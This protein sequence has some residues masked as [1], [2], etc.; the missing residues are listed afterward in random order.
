MSIEDVPA[1]EAM[2]LS[3]FVPL[4]APGA[5]IGSGSDA[6][7]VILHSAHLAGAWITSGSQEAIVAADTVSHTPS[8]AS[9]RWLVVTKDD[10]YLK[11][12]TLNVTSRDDELYVYAV[13]GKHLY[14]P[15]NSGRNFD[16][17]TE[18]NLVLNSMCESLVATSSSDLGYGVQFLTYSYDDDATSVPERMPDDCRPMIGQGCPCGEEQHPAANEQHTTRDEVADPKDIHLADATNG[19]ASDARM[20]NSEQ[21][22]KPNAE[23]GTPGE[24]IKP[25][26]AVQEASPDCPVLAMVPSEK[27]TPPLE[28]S[29][30]SPS[31]NLSKN[32]SE[33]RRLC[34]WTCC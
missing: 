19:L 32:D 25:C 4:L 30:C 15:R 1:D 26:S 8:A 23:H 13:S 33:R 24:A 11:L 29:C 5:S 27:T 16:I 3:G 10:G 20:A 2:T 6:R 31:S 34:K 7:S 22:R 17:G 21:E 9:K 14:Q 18:A 12:V 28:G